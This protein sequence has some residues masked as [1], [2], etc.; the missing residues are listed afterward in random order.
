MQLEADLVEPAR[1]VE[2]ER[3]V[4][5]FDATV[6]KAIWE[7][8]VHHVTGFG[9]DPIWR[10]LELGGN[11]IAGLSEHLRKLI[12]L[13]VDAGLHRCDQVEVLCWTVD[14]SER[15]Q[16]TSPDAY[17]LNRDSP[18]LQIA[19]RQLE[20]L[21]ETCLLSSAIIREVY[22]LDSRISTARNN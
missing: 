9:V 15:Q 3:S 12:E 8:V 10:K 20:G 21:G 18:I 5:L 11:S 17:D 13:Q 7:P 16:G 1:E 14:K 22:M 4:G 2:G 19:A 6:S